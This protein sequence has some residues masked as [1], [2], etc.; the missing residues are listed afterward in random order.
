MCFFVF[1]IFRCLESHDMWLPNL[2]NTETYPENIDITE[3]LE[4]NN[5][6]KAMFISK[7]AVIQVTFNKI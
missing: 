5:E 2:L 7:P 3:L 6:L 1:K 4:N